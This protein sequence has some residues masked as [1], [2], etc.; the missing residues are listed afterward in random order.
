MKR[1]VAIVQ[2]RYASTRLPGKALLPLG[3]HPALWHVCERL[4]EV[5]E[6]DVVVVATTAQGSDGPIVD[7]VRGWGGE[8][9]AFPGDVNDLLS[10][11]IACGRAHAADAIVMVDGDCPLIHPPTI[12]RMVRSLLAAPETE[13]ARLDGRSIEGGVAVLLLSAYEKI[14]RLLPSLEAAKQRSYREHATLCIM[15]RPDWFSIVDVPCFES[16]ATMKHRLWLDTQADYEFLSAVYDEL[17]R[18]G[19]VVDLEKVVALLG[20]RP[21]LRA[22]NAHVRQKPV[23]M[24]AGRVWMRGDGA[25]RLARG[26]RESLGLAVDLGEAPPP[27]RIAEVI[28]HEA[29]D[30]FAPRAQTSPPGIE[31]GLR[32]DADLARTVGLLAQYLGV[33]KLK[34]GY[35]EADAEGGGLVTTDCALCGSAEKEILWVAPTGVENAACLDCG[36]VYLARHPSR[37][38]LSA[39]YAAYAQSHPD[40]FLLDESSAFAELGRRRAA[41]L[42]EQA[43][44]AGSVLDLGC[45]YGHFLAALPRDAF[46]VAMEPSASET[47]F[48]RE[49]RDFDEVWQCGFEEFQIAP[50]TWRGFDAIVSL[51]ALEHVLDPSALVDFARRH[52][53]PEGV[54]MIAVPNLPTLGRD[55]IEHHYLAQGFHLHT[56]HAATLRALLERGGFRIEWMGAEE[57]TAALRSSLLALA[58]RDAGAAPAS[59]PAAPDRAIRQ[60]RDFHRELETAL[61]SLRRNFA[62][63]SR[64]NRGVVVYGAGVHTAALLNAV[65]GNGVLCLVD[66][67]P[68]KQGRTVH[69]LAVVSFED[70]IARGA[71]VLVVSSLASEA[72]LLARLEKEVTPLRIYGIYRDLMK[73]SPAG[74]SPTTL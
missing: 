12:S 35:F 44:T 3:G 9:F 41:W 67:D 4:K 58:R 28:V 40:S 34:S 47:R 22:L 8:V 68:A 13:Y 61:E 73:L 55:L 50:P 72:S 59:P 29:D 60:A 43:G 21:E 52:L 42:R 37:A 57:E 51:H 15:E 17:F 6:V 1:V 39:N 36:H 27:D 64:E 49:Y 38:R 26:L 66:D 30:G 33:R 32:D 53:A 16:L 25:E 10:R 46:R 71:E 24:P 65:P 18:E 54:L 70:A 45:G 63:W 11:Y 62:E 48:L 7:E 23:E 20:T 14:E 31:V 74:E 56:F 2:S 5:P 19:E 69:G